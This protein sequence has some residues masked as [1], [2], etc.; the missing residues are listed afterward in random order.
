MVRRTLLRK[1]LKYWLLFTICAALPAQA[2]EQPALAPFALST[3]YEFSWVGIPFGTLH[4]EAHERLD[5]YQIAADIKLT[6]L[7]SVFVKHSSHTVVSGHPGDFTRG[8][9]VYES[10]YKTRDKPRHVKLGYDAQGHI[11]EEII[12][13]AEN[14]AKRPEVPRAQK[15]GTLDP[16]SLMAQIRRRLASALAAGETEFQLPAFD[17]RR[18]M[19]TFYRIEGRQTI[20][21]EDQKIPVT[22]V[23]VTRQ[24]V[25]GYTRGELDDFA[26]GDPTLIMFFSDLPELMPVRLRADIAVGSLD[27]TRVR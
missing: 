17:G 10:N 3:D 18:Q 23:T 19:Q 1:T 11:T 20:R 15:D 14:R 16:L 13:P 27:A 12:E 21:I 2:E 7:L 9:R 24:P 6:G 25:A 4:V 26:Q 5:D 22:K 8:P